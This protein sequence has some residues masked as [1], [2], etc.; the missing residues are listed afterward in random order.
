MVARVTGWM[1]RMRDR[2]DES[3]GEIGGGLCK[4]QL[5]LKKNG[6]RLSREKSQH[7]ARKL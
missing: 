3:C 2:R 7:N 1:S 5:K 4:K 6:T